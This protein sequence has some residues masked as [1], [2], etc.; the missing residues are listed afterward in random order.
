MGLEQRQRWALECFFPGLIEKLEALGAGLFEAQPPTFRPLGNGIGF[1]DLRVRYYLDGAPAMYVELYVQ[2]KLKAG[3]SPLDPRIPK[4]ELGD[5]DRTYYA[6]SYK[7]KLGDRVFAFDFGS[8]GR[9]VHMR[10]DIAKHIPVD[11]VDPDSTDFDPRAFVDLLSKFRND[12]LYPLKRRK[13]RN[14]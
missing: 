2:L 5:W 14:Q 13:K 12:S 7:R 4:V 3:R 9:H 6:L 8:R 10:P 1:A 11:E